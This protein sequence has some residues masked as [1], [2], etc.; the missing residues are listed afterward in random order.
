MLLY[1][2]VNF[3]RKK[4][5]ILQFFEKFSLLVFLKLCDIL[6]QITTVTYACKKEIYYEYLKQTNATITFD[7]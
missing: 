1:T 5:V 7:C 6:G 3:L 2:Q 4:S